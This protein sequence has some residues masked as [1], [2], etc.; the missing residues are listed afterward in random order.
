M[1][2]WNIT[3]IETMSFNDFY[4]IDYVIFRNSGT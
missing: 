4:G 2:K 3:E 1:I